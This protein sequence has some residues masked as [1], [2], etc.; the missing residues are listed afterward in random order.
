M[1]KKKQYRHP[2]VRPGKKP[3][4]FRIEYYDWDGTR[5][6]KIFQG[7]ETDGARFRR[8]I[9][10]QVDKIKHGL[11]APPKSLNMPQT[12]IELWD[13]FENEYNM[14]VKSGSRSG[15]TLARY[16]N[17]I[18]AI[19]D[20]SPDLAQKQ[21]KK[22][23]GHD[24]EGFKIYRKT[25]GLSGNG[26]NTELRH[27]RAIYNFAI[28]R[29]WLQVNP[30]KEVEYIKVKKQ[31]VRF[32]NETDMYNLYLTLQA[33][34]LTDEYQ[35]DAHDLVL[36]YL[37]TGARASEILYPNFNWFC[38]EQNRIRFPKTKANIERTIPLT[39]NIQTIL[40]SRK[41]I[42]GGP[43]HFDIFKVYNRTSYVFKKANI[44]DA[45]THTLRKTAG[46]YYYVAT[47]DIFAT[48]RFLGHSSVTV[49]ESHYVGL[50]QSLQTEYSDQFDLTVSEML[51]G[52]T[53]Y[54]R[55][56]DTKTDHSVP[57]KLLKKSRKNSRFLDKKQE[58]L[59]SG[60]TGIR[61]PNQRIMSTQFVVKKSITSAETIIHY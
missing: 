33:L 38:I 17:A 59:K 22:V 31:D 48:S 61:T 28:K 12:L 9:L 25:R 26:I 11:V 37:Y 4:T 43:F 52:R 27:L 6:T 32:I 20:Y 14:K 34:D 8:S 54:V 7:S 46:A 47:R 30:V 56:F 49:T 39:E 10:V 60:P 35:K 40:D 29:N 13:S 41:H 57:N 21:L 50:I 58:L 44:K 36:F 24:F 51:S 19:L 45:S 1:M 5:K 53:P 18:D 23:T 42:K 3:G 55:H 2:G 16:R 15:R